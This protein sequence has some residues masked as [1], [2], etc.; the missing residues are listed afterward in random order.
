MRVTYEFIKIE[1]RLFDDHRFFTLSEFEQLIYVKLLGISKRT[2]NR[3]PK[4]VPVLRALL[5]SNRS[6]TEV[7]SAVTRLKEVFP[8]FKEGRY[9]YHF[10]G[11]AERHKKVVPDSQRKTAKSRVEESKTKIK[12]KTKS[13]C[14]YFSLC[15]TET[16]GVSYPTDYGRD[17]TIINDLLEIYDEEVLK[18]LITEFFVSS[19]NPNEWW[20]DKI[21]V[22][23]FKS[24][25]PQLIGKIRKKV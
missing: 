15:Y 20:A 21:S 8:K 16:T 5:R 13:V 25:I 4:E 24:V 12:I 1:I 23:I 9:F 2:K 17:I 19:K 3:I 6:D 14:E 7:I 22:A 18:T 11:F 10:I